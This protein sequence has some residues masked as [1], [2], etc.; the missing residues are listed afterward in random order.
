MKM[1]TKERTLVCLERSKGSFVSGEHLASQ[2]HISRNSVWKAIRSLREDGYAIESV[3]GEGYRL[4]PETGV[5][6]AA[7]ILHYLT[8]ASIELEYHDS[9]DS[10]NTHAKALAEAGAPEGTL[11]VANEQTA[12]RGRRGRVFLSPAGSGVYFSLV[13]RPHFDLQDLA[14][15]TS[16]AACCVAH[17]IEAETGREA[18]IK[19]VNDVFVDARKVSGILT[20]AAFDAESQTLSYAIVGIGI[21]VTSPQG[22]FDP[23]A[24]NI[25]GFLT[26]QDADA[27]DLR[28]RLVADTVD[29]F[30]RHYPHVFEKPHLA[31]YRARSM[32]DGRR[33]HID[34]GHESFE[35]LVCGINDDLTLRVRLDNGE[36]R[37]LSSGDVHIASSQLV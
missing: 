2:M 17:A 21:N 7:S 24:D 35:A 29:A 8:D 16:Y 37:S 13:L 11:V 22:G 33:V 1:S 12:G 15:I 27:G 28:A 4:S 20:E 36:E 26:R 25:A 34:A 5:L 14:F 23:E 32:L 18:K 19:W 30:M 6:S 10:T 3:A 31:D 9:I